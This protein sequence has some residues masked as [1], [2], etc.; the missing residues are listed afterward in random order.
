MEENDDYDDDL[1][2]HCYNDCVLTMMMMMM[3]FAAM[4]NDDGGSYTQ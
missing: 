2:R 4:M 3:M 1:I